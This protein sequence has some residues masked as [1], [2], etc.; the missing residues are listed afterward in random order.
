MEMPLRILAGGLFAVIVFGVTGCRGRCD[1]R[2]L[3][4]GGRA[5]PLDPGTDNQL[6]RRPVAH[7]RL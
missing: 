3:V 6:E 2:Y 4:C 5:Q 1:R 7:R